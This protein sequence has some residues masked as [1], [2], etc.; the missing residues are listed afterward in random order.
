MSPTLVSMLQNASGN[1]N[2]NMAFF[3][4]N[5][6]Q[7]VPQQPAPTPKEM[8]INGLSNPLMSNY[9]NPYM[10]FNNNYN[11]YGIVPGFYG[12]QQ[13]QSSYLTQE[14]LMDPR[15]LATFNEAK[16][17]HL[18]FDQQLNMQTRIAKRIVSSAVAVCEDIKEEEKEKMMKACEPPPLPSEIRRK[19]MNRKPTDIGNPIRPI[20]TRV[21]FDN[22][23]A[24]ETD[25]EKSDIKDYRS[26]YVSG[27]QLDKMMNMEVQADIRAKKINDEMYRT[28]PERQADKAE[29]LIDFFNNYGFI[30]GKAYSEYELRKANIS[31]VTQLYN[32][33]DFIEFMKKNDILGYRDVD[34]PVNNQYTSTKFKDSPN[35]GLANAFNR[36]PNLAGNAVYDPDTD[37]VTITAPKFIRNR[38]AR[39]S[40]TPNAINNLYNERKNAFIRS[41]TG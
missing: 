26:A 19:A 33:E 2:G 23:F 14:D 9:Y 36:S 22:E 32:R 41:I 3:G 29:D 13:N 30:I 1:T 7:A 28:A 16:S 18:T 20:K 38:D 12:N 5:G 17:N 15:V 31:S 27:S 4:N 25:P 6:V 10:G 24:C 8:L 21:Y 39:F 40:G 37:S 34:N 11:N 35:Y